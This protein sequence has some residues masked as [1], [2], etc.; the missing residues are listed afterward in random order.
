VR[1]TLTVWMLHLDGELLFTGDAGITEPSA[2]SRRRGVTFANFYR[3]MPS[4][5]IDADVS[6]AHAEF[7]DGSKIPGALERVIASGVTYSPRTSGVFS[8][9][10]VRHFGSYPLIEDNSQRARSSTLVNA[11]A[12]YRLNSGTRIQVSV[13]NVLDGRADDIQY[14]YS[15]RLRGESSDGVDDVHF[16][17]AEPRQLR[18]SIEWRP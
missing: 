14:A 7:A 15:S 2:A 16:H 3:P 11:D 6:F 10:R 17:P 13:L 9:V 8:S 4:L 1:S 5:A 18:V 12:G